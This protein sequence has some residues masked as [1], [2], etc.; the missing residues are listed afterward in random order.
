MPHEKY[1]VFRSRL[2]QELERARH[3]EHEARGAFIKSA[4]AKS[5]DTASLDRLR[6]HW[7]R[8]GDELDKLLASRDLVLNP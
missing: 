1:T 8:A 6:L 5:V 2:D 7:V 4:L 3:A